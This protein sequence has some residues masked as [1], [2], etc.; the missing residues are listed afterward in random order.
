MAE[1]KDCF[2]IIFGHGYTNTVRP[3]Y[4]PMPHG[5]KILTLLPADIGSDCFSKKEHVTEILKDISRGEFGHFNS[6]PE[7]SLS[8]LNDTLKPLFPEDELLEKKDV[9]DFK[10]FI[11]S[12]GDYSKNSYEYYNKTWLFDKV[13]FILLIRKVS[14]GLLITYL[15]DREIKTGG[16]SITKE[17]LIHNPNLAPFDNYTIIDLSCNSNI[18]ENTSESIAAFKA[19]GIYGG[20]KIKSRHMK[21]K[22]NRSKKR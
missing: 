10:I 16:F 18:E 19:R 6:N 17:M 12:T 15:Y 7:R 8:I 9:E 5:K 13:D 21:R 4:K 2:I 1:S 20:K 14:G 11:E 3:D 22:S